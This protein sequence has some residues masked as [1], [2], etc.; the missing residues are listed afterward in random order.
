MAPIE[1]GGGNP[2]PAA[3]WRLDAGPSSGYG[4]TVTVA[5]PE[6]CLP[7]ARYVAVSVAFPEVPAGT[8][9]GTLMLAPSPGRIAGIAVR[10]A[11]QPL[12][13]ARSTVPA[14]RRTSILLTTRTV[15]SAPVPALSV[16]GGVIVMSAQVPPSHF[17]SK[18]EYVMCS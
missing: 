7:S 10:V 5:L 13:T 8:V 17:R 1:R 3:P 4:V 9:T 12:G 18:E 16:A 14:L 6:A 15:T 11:V 2:R